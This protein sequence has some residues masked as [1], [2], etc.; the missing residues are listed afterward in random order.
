MSSEFK[1]V[2]RQSLVLGQ[3]PLPTV[4]QQPKL[5][6]P[7]E[8]LVTNQVGWVT[9]TDRQ[10]REDEKRKAILARLTEETMGEGFAQCGED[11]S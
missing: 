3:L 5:P 2:R 1:K 11:P 9:F 7:Y 8:L 10:K 4:P 6:D